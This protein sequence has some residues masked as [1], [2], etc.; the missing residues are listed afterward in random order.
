MDQNSLTSSWTS[1]CIRILSI[2]LIVSD[3][4]APM[5]RSPG[6]EL[7][8]V[9]SA[10]A[11]FIFFLWGFIST[12]TNYILLIQR[13]WSF[14]WRV[15][16]NCAWVPLFQILKREHFCHFKVYS[17]VQVAP[18]CRHISCTIIFNYDL[19]VNIHE[20]NICIPVMIY[21]LSEN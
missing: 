14:S 10:G 19:A 15:K 7:D 13:V 16:I 2:Y 21:A 20:H 6:W 8:F 5:K 9:M 12:T 3:W 4:F 11:A 18:I 1:W 17:Y